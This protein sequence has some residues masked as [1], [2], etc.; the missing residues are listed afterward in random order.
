M[1]VKAPASR[2]SRGFRNQRFSA[3][4]PPLATEVTKRFDLG[5]SVRSVRPGREIVTEGKRCT[6]VFLI[7]QGVAMRYRI[8]RDGQRQIVNLLLPGDFAGVTSCHFETALFSIKTLT[9]AAV[10]PIPLSRL[11]R[12]SQSHPTLAEELFRSFASDAAIVAE[13]LIAVGRRS[14]PERVAHLLLELLTRLRQ[15]GL[16]DEHAFQ[17]PL[18]QEIIGDALGLSVPYVNRVLQQLRA[19]GLV[20]IKNKKIEIYNMEELS[21]LADFKH[22]Y[23]RPRPVADPTRAAG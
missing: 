12:L 20:R 6:A 8:L 21:A 7:S 17:L 1:T 15:L 22:D 3:A 4:L 14:A 13:H 19:E 2:A 11:I 16:A 10:H 18:T 9:Q 5:V 23:L